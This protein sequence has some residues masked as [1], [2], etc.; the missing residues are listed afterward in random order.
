LTPDVFA[1]LLAPIATEQFFA[2][3]FEHEP[4][5]VAR[6]DPAYFADVYSVADVEAA[7]HVGAAQ[8]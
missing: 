4:L 6:N 2:E 5:H 7:L 3:H 8:R 1:R